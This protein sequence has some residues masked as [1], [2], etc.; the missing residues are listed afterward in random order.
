MSYCHTPSLTPTLGGT[1]GEV[2]LGE[3]AMADEVI[4][5]RQAQSVLFTP[6]VREYSRP[7]VQGI[8]KKC[9]YL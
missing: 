2:A 3:L 1:M 8:Y 4:R 7:L 5:V 9:S 6:V